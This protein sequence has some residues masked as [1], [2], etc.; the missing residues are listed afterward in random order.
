MTQTVRLNQS[1]SGY[2]GLIARIGCDKVLK[3]KL[4]NLGIRQGQQISVLHQRKNGVVVMSNGSRIA[5]GSGIAVNIFLEPMPDRI[6]EP[7]P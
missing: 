6:S 2:E 4:M 7:Q 5:L 1:A 3:R